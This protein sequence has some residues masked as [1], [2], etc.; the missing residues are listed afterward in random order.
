MH[1]TGT[2][3]GIIHIYI[4]SNPWKE[5]REREGHRMGGRGR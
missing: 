4:C 2:I 1:G 3:G 5:G